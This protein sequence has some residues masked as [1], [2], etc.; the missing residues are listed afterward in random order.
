M[1]TLRK[2]S[3][4]LL[5]SFAASIV[6]LQK[7]LVISYARLI[8][9]NGSDNKRKSKTAD[10][11]IDFPQNPSEI[12]T[13]ETDRFYYTGAVIQQQIKWLETMHPNRP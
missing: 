11:P 5:R 13:N 9:L 8:I 10:T 2:T 4:E 7:T 6:W 3:F 1:I 12:Q